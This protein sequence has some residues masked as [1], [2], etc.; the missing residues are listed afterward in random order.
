MEKK[1]K[2]VLLKLSGEILSGSKGYG[3]ESS[4]LKVLTDEIKKAVN[5]NK[6]E[7]ALVV[8]GGNIWRGEGKSMDRVSADHIGMLAT[9]MNAIALESSLKAVGIDAVVQSAINVSKLAKS[10]VTS[11]AIKYLKQGKIV[12]F[13]AGTGN[14][15]FT[16]D[17]TAALRASEIKA[18][19]FLKA[20]QVDGVYDSDP[21]KNS[22]AKKFSEISYSEAIKR[23]LKVMDTSAFSLC[24]ENALPIMVFD[25]Y[26]TGN[27][28]KALSGMKIGTIV[29]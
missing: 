27:L 9:I 19:I 8:G 14:P 29:S 16:T 26:K 23:N 18:D 21:K 7:L 10:Y 22:K 15:Y 6:V 2:R 1:Y 17:T 13:A 11:D 25:F 24:M 28:S 3:I 4:G 12:I 20:T 5:K